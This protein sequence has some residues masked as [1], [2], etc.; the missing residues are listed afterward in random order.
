MNIKNMNIPRPEFP[1]PQLVR[2]TWMNL[3][4]K[5]DFLFDFGNSGCARGLMNGDV[6]DSGDVREITV[7]FCP[8]SRLSGIGYTD[9]IAAVWYRRHFEISE[10]QLRGRVLLH[11]GAVDYRCV[12]W[13]NGR[14]VGSHRGGYSSFTFDITDSATMLLSFT[15]P[16]T[17][18]A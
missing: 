4:G 1:R 13:I 12:V 10:K 11:F 3:N 5:W 6:F 2:D 16:M 17:S 8:E 18:G 9:F 15:Q 7:P 14:E